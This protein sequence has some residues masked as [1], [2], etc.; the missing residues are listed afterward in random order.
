MKKKIIGIIICT[1]FIFN[2]FSSASNSGYSSIKNQLY[3][4]ESKLVEKMSINHILIDGIWFIHGLFRYLGE[5]EDYIYLKITTAKLFGFKN[6]IFIYRLFFCKVKVS[7]PFSGF[8]TKRFT[9]I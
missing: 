1:L 7:K 9:I 3:T 5:D 8:L 2:A 4:N 6:G